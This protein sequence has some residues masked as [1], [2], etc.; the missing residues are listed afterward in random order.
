MDVA[1]WISDVAYVASLLETSCKCFKG[2]F[3]IFHLFMTYVASNLI[4]MLHMFHTYV[5]TIC[6][7]C[8]SLMMW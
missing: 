8:F 1:R 2:L 4:W 3:K 5:A 7:K 6:F